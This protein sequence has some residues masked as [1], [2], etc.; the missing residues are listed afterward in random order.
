MC[1][2]L[3]ELYYCGLAF[4]NTD[5]IPMTLMHIKIYSRSQKCRL[6]TGRTPVIGIKL[7]CLEWQTR[8]CTVH[9]SRIQYSSPLKLEP[10]SIL[11]DYYDSELAPHHILS[12]MARPGLGSSKFVKQRDGLNLPVLLSHFL[13]YSPID[14]PGCARKTLYT[15][16]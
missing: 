7:G 11:S 9:G 15:S 6:A 14:I 4:R 16:V 10:H 12:H 13:Q 2:I 1:C 5:A 8:V 3:V